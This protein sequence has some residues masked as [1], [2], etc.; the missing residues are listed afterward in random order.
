VKK[1]INYFGTF[2]AIESASREDIEKIT[3]KKISNI[4]KDNINNCT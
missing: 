4:M 3:N 1:L 2:E